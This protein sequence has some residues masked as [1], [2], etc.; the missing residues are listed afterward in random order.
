M[1]SDRTATE[2]PG[3]GT[4]RALRVHA[5]GDLRVDAV[6][7]PTPATDQALIR[8]R[9]GGVCGSDVHYWQSGAVG[10]SVLRGP[11]VLGHEVVGTVAVPASDGSGPPQDRDVAIHPAQSCGSCRWCAT[12]QPN[13]CPDSRYMGSAAQWPHTDGGFTD[14]LAVATSRLIELPDGLGLRRASLVE[15]TGIAWHAA[16]RAEAVGAALRGAKVLVVGAG[17]IGL[18]MTAVAIYRGAASTTVTDLHSRP[19]RVAEEVGADRV[20]TAQELASSDLALGVDIAFESSGSVP[21]LAT[22]IRSVRRGGTVVAVGHLPSTAVPVPAGLIVSLELTVTGSLRLVSEL[23]AAIVL[24]ADP[25]AR[26]D[27]IVTDV[28]PLAHASDAFEMAADSA[29]S[30]KV[31]L[32]FAP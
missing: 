22:A 8:V 30:S 27:S 23:P 7:P 5:A 11:M 29:R 13:L 12:G 20:I 10:A 4:V 2:P 15:P 21:G 18:L 32:D 9:Y 14:L 1:S 28:Y 16:S 6:A 31:L 3:P 26:V 19:L 17:P 25:R 24:L